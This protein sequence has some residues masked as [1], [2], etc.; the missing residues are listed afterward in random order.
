MGLSCSGFPNS[1]V[2][3]RMECNSGFGNAYDVE[4]NHEETPGAVGFK[5]GGLV[6]LLPF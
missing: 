5:Q 3:G 1:R 2:K 4:D 6:R